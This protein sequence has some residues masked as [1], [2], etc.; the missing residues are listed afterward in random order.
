MFAKGKNKVRILIRYTGLKLTSNQK[1]LD[2]LNVAKIN[3]TFTG[4]TL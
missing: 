1:L 3:Y 2:M 4:I